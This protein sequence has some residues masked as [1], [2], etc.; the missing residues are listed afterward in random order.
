LRQ[1]GELVAAEVQM[2]ERAKV[3]DEVRYR[4][5]MESTEIQGGVSEFSSVAYPPCSFACPIIFHPVSPPL[6][7]IEVID[8][9]LTV[10]LRLARQRAAQPC[11]TTPMAE[12]DR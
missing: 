3:A 5:Q 6:P 9:S 10:T 1:G 4:G 2:G 12:A 11:Q 8:P 7:M